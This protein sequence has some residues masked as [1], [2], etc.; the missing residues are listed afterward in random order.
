[1]PEIEFVSLIR[2]IQVPEKYQGARVRVVGWGA[3]EFE[4]QA[5]YATADDFRHAVTKNALWLDIR[6]DERTRKLHGKCVL[7]EATFDGENRGHLGM[8]SGCLADVTRA[9][10]WS[11]GHDP[12]KEPPAA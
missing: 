7:V 6:S 3:V 12:R 10:I 4:H 5:L 11:E 1:M 8:F 2:L 9:E